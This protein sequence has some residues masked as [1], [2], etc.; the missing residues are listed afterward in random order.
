MSD[1]NEK[2]LCET[3]TP[4]KQAK[5]IEKWKY[6]T[7]RAAILKVL[8]RQGEGVLFQD[9]PDLV[10]AHLS[11]AVKTQLG[12]VSW[13]TTTVKLDLE[14]RGEI[15]RVAGSKPQRLLRNK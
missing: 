10:E 2:V 13:Y 15:V 7:V 12:S 4:G 3:P 1:K 9:L 5:R 14:V 11:D 8:P 6:A